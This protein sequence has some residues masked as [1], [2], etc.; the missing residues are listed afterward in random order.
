MKFG[1]DLECSPN[2]CRECDRHVNWDNHRFCAVHSECYDAP[3]RCASCVQEEEEPAV[4][5]QPR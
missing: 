3:G 5:S 2:E 1:G 4:S